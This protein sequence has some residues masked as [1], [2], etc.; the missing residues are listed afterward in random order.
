MVI[1]Q[2]VVP[3]RCL[4]ELL[5]MLGDTGIRVEPANLP[6]WAARFGQQLARWAESILR[7]QPERSKMR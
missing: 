1:G 6:L 4:F 2:L 3:P 5:R 7:H